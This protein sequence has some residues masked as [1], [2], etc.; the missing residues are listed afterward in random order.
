MEGRTDGTKAGGFQGL[1]V[2]VE[3]GIELVGAGVELFRGVAGFAVEI[4][5]EAAKGDEEDEED[6][7]ADGDFEDEGFGGVSMGFF[8]GAV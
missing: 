4:A 6:D 1:V 3:D 2:I 5:E 8:G 7:A